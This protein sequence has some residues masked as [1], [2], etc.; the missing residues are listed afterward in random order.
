MPATYVTAY[1]GW[2]LPETDE[3]KEMVQRFYPD[4]I[5]EYIK[6]QREKYPNNDSEE[7]IMRS[8]SPVEFIINEL[9]IDVHYT[10]DSIIIGDIG[11]IEI[12][13]DCVSMEE[14]HSGLDKIDKTECEKLKELPVFKELGEPT[15]YIAFYFSRN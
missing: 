4:A 3:L 10:V 2:K 9:N 13:S 8:F 7:I 12:S 14:L 1:N 6:Y 11:R 5:Q 15:I